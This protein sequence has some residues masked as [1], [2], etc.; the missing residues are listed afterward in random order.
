M[1]VSAVAFTLVSIA[2]LQQWICRAKQ[3][4]LNDKTSLSITE[5]LILNNKHK[6]K[7]KLSNDDFAMHEC[8][9]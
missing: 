5:S 7:N 3:S 1:R 8:T 9:I 4:L 6:F 2:D